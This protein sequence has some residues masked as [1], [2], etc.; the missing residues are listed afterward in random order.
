MD[1]RTILVIEDER[2]VVEL[3]SY[4][5]DKAGFRVMAAYDG[6]TGLAIARDRRPDLIILDLMLPGIDGFSV[7]QSLRDDFRTLHTPIL[8][9]T[10]RGETR[11]RVQGFRVGADDYM[12]KPFSLVELLARIRALARRSESTLD[13]NPLTHLAGNRAIQE[14]LDALIG[15]GLPFVALYADI[16]RFKAY[17][18][19]YGSIQGD[20]LIKATADILT[21]AVAASESSLRFV[22]HIGGDDFVIFCEPAWADPIARSAI[23]AFDTKAP[24]FIPPVAPGCGTSLGGPLGARL[25]T[26]VLSVP[27]LTVVGV[28]NENRR[29]VTPE[30]VSVSLAVLKRLAKGRS[31]GSFY[32]LDRGN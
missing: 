2:D 24:V 30:Q 26:D 18:D 25:S 28:L 29:F 32:T 17:N 23:S 8:M 5:L 15:A 27:T 6:E 12:P 3:L 9:L 1:S 22:G 13:A 14:R 31:G 11:D 20:R 21:E 4:N 16:D 19:R 7:C 10:A